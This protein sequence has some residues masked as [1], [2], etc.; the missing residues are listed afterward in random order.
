M[1]SPREVSKRTDWEEMDALAH[2][3]LTGHA[4]AHHYC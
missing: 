4:I 1:M 3:A 2:V